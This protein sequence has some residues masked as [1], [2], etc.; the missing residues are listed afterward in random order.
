MSAQQKSVVKW[1]A[2]GITIALAALT[3]SF[4]AP[5]YIHEC[6]RD[7]VAHHR[8]HE[9]HPLHTLQIERVESRLEGR[10]EKMEARLIQE[11]RAT[12]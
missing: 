7:A 8:E 3:V 9:T 11:I 6:T 10:I 2:V 1:V 5:G 4:R 12:R